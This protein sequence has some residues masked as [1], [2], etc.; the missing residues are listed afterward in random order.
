[1]PN[2]DQTN[3]DTA[4]AA[5]GATLDVGE[6]L[7]GDGLG[8]ACDDEDDNESGADRAGPWPCRQHLPGGD[9][10]SIGGL[11]RGLSGHRRADALPPDTNVDGKVNILDVAEM[12]DYWRQTVESPPAADP[13]RRYDLNADGKTNIVDVAKMAPFWRT[14]CT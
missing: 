7:M 11:R 12:I 9:P 2:A 3:T 4:L 10:P 5:A 6:P 13:G 8:D 14:D 1:M